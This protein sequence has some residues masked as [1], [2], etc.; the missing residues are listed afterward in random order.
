MDPRCRILT[1]IL[2]ACMAAAIAVPAWGQK[3]KALGAEGKPAAAP[4]A[5]PEG[6]EPEDPAVQAL[7]ETNPT[8]PSE[9][10]AVAKSLAALGKP[11]L[12]KDLLR[13]VLAAKLDQKQWAALGERLGSTVFFQLGARA[14]LQPEGRQ[15]ADAVLSALEAQVRDSQRVAGLIKQLQD[16]SASVR[17]AAL[18]GLQQAR[19]AAVGPL[20]AVLADASRTAEH[21]NVR[22]AL[23]RMGPD[24]VRPL[25]AV[26]DTP[27][28][29]LRVEAIRALAGMDAR[30]AA[31][32]L[33]AP[34]CARRAPYASPQSSAEVRTAAEAALKR[35]SGRTPE[36]SEAVYTLTTQAR[37]YFDGR[38]PIPEVQLGQVQV[39]S[40]DA[41]KRQLTGKILATE[42]AGRALAARLAR[43]AYSVAPEDPSVRLLY[44]AT[45]LEQASYENG[46]DKPLKT[47]PKTPAGQAA[48]L[49]PQ[50]VEA[51]LEFGLAHGHVA[52][53]TAAARILGHIGLAEQL[54]SRAG[55]P[56]PLVRAVH[57]PD[58]RLRFAAVEAI[59]ALRPTEPFPGCSFVPAALGFFASSSGSR[60]I[61]VADASL[62]EA[63]RLSAFLAALGYHLDTATNGREALRVAM[64]SADF[65]LVL[66]DTGLDQ[67][68]VDFFVQQLRR[69]FRTGS[70]PVG[71]M[72]RAGHLET[73]IP[74]R[75]RDRRV[76][77]ARRGRRLR[78]RGAGA[79]RHGRVTGRV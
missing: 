25:I 36:R 30:E 20:L 65:E 76:R 63:R 56:G 50:A 22:A 19:D 54:Q 3:P 52:A 29:G 33:L 9:G 66:V 7:L 69:D 78:H 59:L 79:T 77:R 26:L 45:M 5:I 12:A 32:F 41:A 61:M 51:V 39:W 2:I 14:D 35:L 8:T 10:I 34:Y 23:A 27:E 60:R 48:A 18:L 40:W 24:A 68:P 38:Q 11:K 16:P 43:E 6:S 55:Q 42:D 31:V 64:E 15:V 44:L 70:I 49:G 67:P 74:R 28:P 73:R 4:S 57:H 75:R 13:R 17:V 21:R 53:A 71:I 58:A 62:I 46:L 1:V 37:L 47:D 72:A